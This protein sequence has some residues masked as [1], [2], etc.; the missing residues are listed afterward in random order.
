MVNHYDVVLIGE[1]SAVRSW[2]RTENMQQRHENESDLQDKSA[3]FI[4]YQLNKVGTPNNN[5]T[6]VYIKNYLEPIRVCY[7]SRYETQP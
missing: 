2:K 3:S 7:Q 1:I 4:K 6:L 5:M